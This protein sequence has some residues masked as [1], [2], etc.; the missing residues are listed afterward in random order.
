MSLAC[1]TMKDEEQYYYPPNSNSNSPDWARE[2]NASGLEMTHHGQ[3]D[4]DYDDAVNHHHSIRMALQL[5]REALAIFEW[6]KRHALLFDH[7][8]QSKD[9][10]V[11]M[12]CTLSK[13]GNLLRKLNDFVGAAGM[14]TIV[15]F[16]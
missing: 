2:L 6:N 7:A 5:H 3:V 16:T 1:T 11:E 9:Y 4:G 15:M 8:E 10:A 12:A 14:C 13:I